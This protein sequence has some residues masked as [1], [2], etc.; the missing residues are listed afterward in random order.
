MA[1]VSI[2]QGQL[3]GSAAAGIHAFK[4]I[5]FAA[6]TAGLNRWRPPQPAPG[7]EGVRPATRFGATCAQG[8]MPARALMGKAGRQYLDLILPDEPRGD[9]CLNLNVFTPSVDPDAR[10]PVMYW[11]HGGALLYGSGSQA[12]YDGT[13]LARKGVVVV[14]VNYR[15]GLIGFL[16]GDSHFEGDVC[17]GNRGFMD[18]VAGLE[19]V[20][21]NIR[22]F[23][24]DPS[25]VTIFG[26]SAGG[27]SVAV[28]LASPR[29]EG[30]FQ[31]AILQSGGDR[32]SQATEDHQNY[33]AAV[34]DALGV[35]RGD[36]DALARVP[37]ESLLGNLAN[38]VFRKSRDQ[39]GEM[40]KTGSAITGTHGT[41]FMPHAVVDALANG[42]ASDVDLMI[43]TNKDE[44]RLFS[45]ILPGPRWL[46]SRSFSRLTGSII[47]DRAAQ[48]EVLRRY[49]A[50]LP[51]ESGT[52]VHE[53]LTTD[54]T[55]RRGCTRIA[56]A[57]AQ[58]RPGHTFMYEF[59]W[60][61]PVLNGAF[62]A[63]HALEIPF[64]FDNLERAPELVGSKEGAQPLA[65]SMSDA[66]VS[67]ARDGTPAARELPDWPAFDAGE[68]ATM[69]FDRECRLEKDPGAEIRAIWESFD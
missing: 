21:E 12:I 69:V 13:P 26:E 22:A 61:S 23:G 18:Q 29:S 39:L 9:D 30:L 36:A 42:S 20:Q 41:D 11:I 47:G 45:L 10:L 16:A 50:A 65:D 53:Q 4:G 7:W 27:T 37:V 14:T 28:L 35:A 3:E 6:S 5:P 67:F 33:A 56:E 64:A 31:R 48:K 24:G 34:L 66:W 52:R 1:V 58:K 2:K 68:R 46:A 63:V 17:A 51:G 60:E 25:N 54:L 15:L 38:K 19:W 57:H 44:G 43:G 62:G 8:G 55:F 32:Q 40:G 49:R 59:H